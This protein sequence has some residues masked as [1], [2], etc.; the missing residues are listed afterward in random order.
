MSTQQRRRRQKASAPSV[1]SMVTAAVLAYGTYQLANWAWQSWTKTEDE[2]QEQPAISGMRDVI[3]SD[4]PRQ[5]H[6]LDISRQRWR[7][8]RQRMERCREETANALIDFLPTMR[9]AIENLTDTTLETKELKRMRSERSED[10]RSEEKEHWDSIKTKAMTKMITTAYGHSILLLVLTVQVHLLGGHL[11]DE[12]MKIQTTARSI[13]ADSLASDRMT[14]YQASHRLVLT[15]TYEYFFETGIVLLAE[16][17][18]RAVMTVMGDW[19][20]TNPESINTT[21]EMLNDAIQEIRE[22]VEGRSKKSSRRPRSILRFLLPTEQAADF[23]NEDDLARST[24]DETWDLMES[25]VFEDALRDSLCATFDIMKNQFWL[26]IFLDDQGNLPEHVCQYTKKP[27]VTVVTKLKATSNS[28]YIQK[29]F[30]PFSS[31]SSTSKYIPVIQQIRTILELG[32][33]SFN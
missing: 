6:N 17:V 4:P 9:R 20:V 24:L 11:F 3:V 8:R 14:S 22:I 33:V 7:L 18:E 32:D 5:R 13:G 19:D 1:G 30:S 21:S 31:K 16:T 23:E 28:F 25:P 2:E 26:H 10:S 29:P 27:L 12:Q 15:R